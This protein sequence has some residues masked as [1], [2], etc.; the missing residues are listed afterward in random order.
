M[1]EEIL[2]E[3]TKR[4]R[5]PKEDIDESLNSDW[6]NY[7]EGIIDAQGNW[8]N[9]NGSHMTALEGLCSELQGINI[10]TFRDNVPREVYVDYST[11]LLKECKGIAVRFSYSEGV[12]P[13]EEALE[14]Y[15]LLCELGKIEDVNT[16]EESDG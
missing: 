14:T 12:E 15:N 13:S 2:W 16:W 3:N 9:L 11:Y 10:S 7:F 4:S 5:V 6:I 8:Y 1:F